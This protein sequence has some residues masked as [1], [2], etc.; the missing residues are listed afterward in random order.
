MT[1]LLQARLSVHYGAT[2]ILNGLELSLARGE[3]VGLVG[4]SGS[5]KSTLGLSLL[6]LIDRRGG[7]ISGSIE[8]EGTDLMS[9][10]ERQL[11]RLRGPAI[12][13]VLQSA[14][15]AL[16]PALRL[17]SHF[18]EAWRA[19]ASTPWSNQRNHILE[20]FA[21][22]GLPANSEFLRRFPGQISVGQAQRVLIALAILH[23]PRLLIADELTASLDLV[24]TCEVLKTLERVNRKWGTAILFVSHDLGAVASLCHR[25]A[26]LSGGRVIESAPTAE[27]FRHPQHEYTRQLISLFEST[28][29]TNAA[30]LASS[31]SVSTP[32]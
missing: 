18:S 3:I 11:R 17:E 16:N 5:G 22:L 20:L 15:S 26:I 12:S 28:R 23:R 21:E 31:T 4:Q 8:F 14:S 10:T 30:P 25:V 2:A 32:D 7:S 1:S 9:L 6:R 27:L 19:H 13:L 29:L 24:T